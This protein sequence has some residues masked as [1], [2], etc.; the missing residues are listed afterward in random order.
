M[1]DLW[2]YFFGSHSPLNPVGKIVCS[3][4]I[5]LVLAVVGIGRL[6]FKR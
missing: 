1:R 5:I 6:I 4:L 2:E 3:P